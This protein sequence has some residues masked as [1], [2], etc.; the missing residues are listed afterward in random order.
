[1]KFT[2]FAHMERA[3]GKDLARW[4]A[5]LYITVSRLPR[6]QIDSAGTV[7]HREFDAEVSYRK[8]LP[9][10]VDPSRFEA[11]CAICAADCTVEVER[12]MSS[13][14]AHGL[15]WGA[16]GVGWCVGWM[17]W[18]WTALMERLTTTVAQPEAQWM[19][20]PPRHRCW[21]CV[22]LR[23]V[24]LRCGGGEQWAGLVHFDLDLP[25]CSLHM[26]PQHGGLGSIGLARDT[27]AASNLPLPESLTGTV[28]PTAASG[29]AHGAAP[30]KGGAFVYNCIPPSSLPPPPPPSTLSLSL[31]SPPPISLPPLPIPAVSTVCLQ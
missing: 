28:R 24:A 12:G 15:L 3:C 13:F 14:R 16:G 27:S 22:A 8:D 10:L 30:R 1:M 25:P 18:M 17:A 7:I 23:Y 11:I 2:K 26:Q 19:Q 5:T 31:S 4:L 9:W 21:R 29:V 6:E 20:Q